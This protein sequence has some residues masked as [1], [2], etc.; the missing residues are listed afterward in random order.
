MKSRQQYRVK[1][2]QL[3]L[4]HWCNVCKAVNFS[5]VWFWQR[6]RFFNS[7]CNLM[8]IV[9]TFLMITPM[10]FFEIFSSIVRANLYKR[11]TVKFFLSCSTRYKKTSCIDW[12]ELFNIKMFFSFDLLKFHIIVVLTLIR[13]HA[14]IFAFT[15]LRAFF[16]MF[17]LWL[18]K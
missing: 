15:Y 13:W 4:S 8:I 3:Y 14:K 7:F 1:L 5:V 16:F 17:I 12:K 11:S 2:T 10:R 18:M 6:A 9:V